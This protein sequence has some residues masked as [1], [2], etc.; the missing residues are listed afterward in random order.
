MWTLADAHPLKNALA[1]PTK[2]RWE[3][4]LLQELTEPLPS[5]VEC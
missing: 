3:R 2:P 1:T 5:R 4:W